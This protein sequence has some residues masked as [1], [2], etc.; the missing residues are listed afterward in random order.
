MK[1][2]V[3]ALVLVINTLNL[4]AASDTTLRD[5]NKAYDDD[6]HEDVVRLF[7][8]LLAREPAPAAPEAADFHYKRAY[9]LYMLKRYDD[10]RSDL[11]DAM[12]LGHETADGYN[13]LALVYSEN[14]EPDRA[15][16]YGRRAVE[17]GR[18]HARK[19]LETYAT[20]LIAHSFE[21]A[22]RD[23]DFVQGQLAL[24]A[25]LSA[26][27]ETAFTTALATD[28]TGAH[29]LAC[30]LRRGLARLDLA[31]PAAALEDVQRVIELGGESASVIALLGRSYSQ[32]G[33]DIAAYECFDNAF[34][35]SSDPSDK[36]RYT[37]NLAATSRK[38]S[39]QADALHHQAQAAWS[40]D[41]IATAR[42][43]Y[44]QAM[45]L[46]GGRSIDFLTGLL[47]FSDAQGRAFDAQLAPLDE[48]G[49]TGPPESILAE[50]QRLKQLH[51]ANTR[52]DVV[53]DDAFFT[54]LRSRS[55]KAWS[56]LGKAQNT[57]YGEWKKSV[58]LLNEA[59]KLAPGSPHL[60]LY[61]A[62]YLTELKDPKALP[63]IDTAARLFGGE[64]ASTHSRR[65]QYYL[66]T[67]D[68]V[69]AFENLRAALTI[70]S[71]ADQ[72]WD[73]STREF[74]R[75]QEKDQHT[76]SDT[77]A[78]SDRR[79]ERRRAYDLAQSNPG[80]EASDRYT[81][82]AYANAHASV[83]S[84]PEARDAQNSRAFADFCWA[85]LLDPLNGNAYV[86]RA[87]CYDRENDLDGALADFT[88][89]KNVGHPSGND[90]IAMIWGKKASASIDTWLK[91]G[92]N[93]ASAASSGSASGPQI[94]GS[95]YCMRCSATGSIY[96]YED[97]TDAYNHRV[98]VEKRKSCPECNGRGVR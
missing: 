61:R 69:R 4:P 95:R 2:L 15:V 75:N 44:A 48:L 98:R 47:A 27:A 37:E 96:V 85:L 53:R 25:D 17:L 14:G 93:T 83:L 94:S 20:N 29:E 6:R 45:I 92:G 80:S 28:P 63:D 33:N 57:P 36:K 66:K 39:A 76:S 38:L 21:F 11:F 50:Y 71:D 43:L 52:L 58:K 24:E 90:G 72:A 26:E 13:L 74:F 8:E 46:P 55:P 19:S 18:I 77:D 68:K 5:A 16:E 59:I 40:Q 1:R 35:L 81:A 70:H 60:H 22:G 32:L 78:P 97:D 7:T 34:R 87:N 86:G 23:S 89:A 91:T 56:L 3:V 62:A 41:D 82:L 31:Q 73:S 54:L 65:G 84:S 12:E 67:G 49:R 64:S 88:R 79:S 9:S 30:R 42:S 10:A 51:P